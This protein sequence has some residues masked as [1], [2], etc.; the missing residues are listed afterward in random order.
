MPYTPLTIIPPAYL[1]V[2]K[3]SMWHN[4]HYC[5]KDCVKVVDK[6]EMYLPKPEIIQKYLL[7]MTRWRDG[8]KHMD[9]MKVL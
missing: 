3:N 9:G 8:P 4:D 6:E 2:P 1:N 7:P 5:H